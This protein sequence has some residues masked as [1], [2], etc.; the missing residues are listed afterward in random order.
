MHSGTA[1]D[2]LAGAIG[3]LVDAVAET[4]IGEVDQREGAGALEARDDRVPLRRS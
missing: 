2:H 1:V 4:E 3:V